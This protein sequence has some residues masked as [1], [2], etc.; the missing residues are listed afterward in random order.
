METEELLSRDDGFR[1]LALALAGDP[2]AADDLAQETWV[3]ATRNADLTDSGRRPAAGWL[4]GVAKWLLHN[5]HRADLR[6]LERERRQARPESTTSDVVLLEELER[7][8]W[9]LRALRRVS[10]ED[11]D[12]LVEHYHDEIG[13]AELAR[14]RKVPRTTIQ[15][16]LERARERLR[17]ELKRD[18]DPGDYWPALLLLGRSRGGSPNLVTAAGLGFAMSAKWIGWGIIVISMLG[19]GWWWGEQREPSH[20]VTTAPDNRVVRPESPDTQADSAP[21]PVLDPDVSLVS[22]PSSPSPLAIDRQHDV[23]GVVLDPDDR[24]VPGAEVGVWRHDYFDGVYLVGA[25]RARIRGATQTDTR[26]EFRIPIPRGLLH[27]LRVHHDD[28]AEVRRQVTAGQR[29]EIRLAPGASIAGQVLDEEG[30]PVARAHVQTIP[31]GEARA[32]ET[33]DDGSFLLAGVPAGDNTLLVHHLMLEDHQEQVHLE[34]GERLDREIILA[35]G[36]ALFGIVRD[37]ISGLPIPNATVGIRGY[38]SDGSVGT[39]EDGS[40]E[41]PGFQR[42]YCYEFLIAAPGYATAVR[43]VVFSQSREEITIEL[44]QGF[45]VRGRLLDPHGTPVGD[46]PI[47]AIGAKIDGGSSLVFESSGRTASDGRFRIDGLTRGVAQV[48]YAHRDGDATLCHPIPEPA[49]G[50]ADT[51]IGDL[52][53]AAGRRIEGVV[54]DTRDRPVSGVRISLDVTGT[55]A[56]VDLARSSI[57]QRRMEID[58]LGRFSFAD[59][60]EGRY[61]IHGRHGAEKLRQEVEV[62][63]VAPPVSVRFEVE[64]QEALRGRVV[65]PSGEPVSGVVV[66]EVGGARAVTDG[67]GR[68]EL[69]GAGDGA[70]DL[71]GRLLDPTAGASTYARTR[72]LDPT[73]LADGSYDL[74]M[75]QSDPVSLVVLDHERRPMPLARVVAEVDSGGAD[76]WRAD[77]D[78]RLELPVAESGRISFT[79]APS[80]PLRAERGIHWVSVAE[81]CRTFDDV[82][83]GTRLEVILPKAGLMV[84]RVVDRSGQGVSAAAVFVRY[85]SGVSRTVTRDDGR[86]GLRVIPEQPVDLV[87]IP[88]YDHRTPLD[89]I[90]PERRTTV[91]NVMPDA[92]EI[93]VTIR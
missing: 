12:L 80:Q 67:Q 22:S 3:V 30:Q 1:R 38:N 26:G 57:L 23:H 87:V 45:S 69:V 86:F 50:H 74:V 75:A 9:V 15:S 85:A 53:L 48:A 7:R 93:V 40:F 29:V 54:V 76:T 46:S 78:G 31:D 27:E 41:W 61:V 21:R 37:R 18:S 11:R 62:G 36:C 70:L 14:R 88:D 39:R 81:L 59:L 77:D 83:A 49:P 17:A 65:G 28:Y 5:R 92:R 56:A 4:V 71:R 84:G 68:F 47:F 25:P 43:A 35:K 6:R 55:G 60:P 52:F 16:R 73:P 51:D 44:D 72:W 24:P 63:G 79:V 32:V 90:D 64:F 58:D 20:E 91:S 34:P 33:T 89:E 19:L 2:D 13:V 8:G 10:R 42:R 66:H 82:P